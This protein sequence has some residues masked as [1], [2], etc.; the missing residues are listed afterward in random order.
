MPTFQVQFAPG[1]LTANALDSDGSTVLAIHSV[2]SW[3]DATAI[4]LTMDVP[5]PSTGTGTAVVRDFVII[6]LAICF[7]AQ[8]ELC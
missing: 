4:N 5:S 8:H 2:S 7:S 1:K 3:G 6:N